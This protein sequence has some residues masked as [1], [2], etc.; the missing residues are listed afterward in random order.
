MTTPSRF[1]IAIAIAALALP[2]WAQAPV[3]A[4]RAGT[5]VG[6]NALVCGKVS[7]ARVAENAEGQPLFFYF[8]E[9]FPRHTFSVRIDKAD[10]E[11]MPAINGKHDS[12]VGKLLCAQGD[13]TGNRARPEMQ[14]RQQANI[15]L[16]QGG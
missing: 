14:V 16:G 5:A 4:A 1:A 2:A 8:E 11:K 3:P 13:V 9:R 7:G 10:L 12:F 6:Q 15:K